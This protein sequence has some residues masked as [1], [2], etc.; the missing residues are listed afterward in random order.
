MV[1]FINKIITIIL[2]F[3]ML[4]LAPLLITY[5]M[6]DLRAQRLVLNEVSQFIDKVTDKGTITQEDLDQLYLAVNSHG[7]ILDVVVKRF[8]RVASMDPT[9]GK[10]RTLYFAADKVEDMNPGD[11]IQVT[12]REVG[13]S[14][15][16]TL[17][18]KLLKVDIGRLE[19][20]LAGT[21]R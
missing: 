6:E 1:D 21:V 20:S 11:I 13:R 19:F 18:Y 8:V 5:M 17:T 10:V 15:V 7:K 2:I 3:V 12:V 16:R 9:T 4:V 14:S